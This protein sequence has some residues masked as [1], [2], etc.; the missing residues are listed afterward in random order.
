[1]TAAADDPAGAW[2][3]L[4]RATRRRLGPTPAAFRAHSFHS[5]ASQLA[6]FAHH[7]RI[8]LDELTEPE[9]AIVAVSVTEHVGTGS[10]V[11]VYA[12]AFHR[13]GTSW[14]A[15]IDPS[16]RIKATLPQ[17]GGRI[18]Q[19]TKVLAEFAARAPLTAAAFWFDGAA[20]AASG[21][22]VDSEHAGM[23]A[24][25]PQPLHDGWHTVVAFVAAGR[26]A[27]ARAWA[28]RSYGGPYA[29]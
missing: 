14:L 6:P 20:V 4:S 10:R 21:A 22:G 15:V 2:A 16:V 19:R 3:L 24:E 17:P 7:A 9:F 28:F 1:M 5:L 27:A 12:A 11:V 23:I 18:F 26:S 13:E 8:F 25:A 29:G